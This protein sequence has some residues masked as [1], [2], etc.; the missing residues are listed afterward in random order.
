MLNV[1]LKINH[2]ASQNDN[3]IGGLIICITIL[4]LWIYAGHPFKQKDNDAES[5]QRTMY[6]TESQIGF[7]LLILI[8]IF[9]IYRAI[10]YYFFG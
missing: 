1:L 5:I 4:S 6:K 9:S 10:D 8:A 3:I 2:S 7:V